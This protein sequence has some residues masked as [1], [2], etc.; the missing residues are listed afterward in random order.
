MSS[1]IDQLPRHVLDQHL[2]A[3]FTYV[4]PCQANAFIHRGTLLRDVQSGR[5]NEKLLLA[6]CAIASRFLPSNQRSIPFR[7]D[8]AQAQGWA[9]EAKT[10][11]VLE[12]MSMDTVATALL[13]AK[14]DM[15]SGKYGTAWML[16]SIANRAA[17]ALGLHKDGGNDSKTTWVERE[18]R[19]RLMW[20]CYC[21]DRM[22][23][24]GVPEFVFIRYEHVR[25]QLPCEEHQYLLGIPCVTPVPNLEGE[26]LGIGRVMPDQ[27]TPERD[28]GMYG[29]YVQIVGIRYMILK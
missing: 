6:I 28:I 1:S 23:A 20:A 26:T 25:M 16:S 10:M 7:Q 8:S 12:E 17:L 19:R 14:Y 13:L 22:M 11:L 18:T 27:A 15:N 24:T 4:Y 9:R 21:L 3:F 5:A 2:D 29:H